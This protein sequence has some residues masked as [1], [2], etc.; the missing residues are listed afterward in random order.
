[1][2]RKVIPFIL[3]ILIYCGGGGESPSSRGKGRKEGT[4]LSSE[5][6]PVSPTTNTPINLRVAALSEKNPEYRWTV[7]GMEQD[8]S[9]STLS[10]KY[11]SEGDTV[12]CSVLINDKEKKKIGPIVIQNTPPQIENVEIIPDFIHH[13]VD[14]SVEVNYDEPDDDEVS[15]DVK[16]Y[17]NSKNSGTGLKLSGSKIKAG[18]SVYAEVTP[19]DESD[20]GETAETK[21]II[22]GNTP[23]EMVSGPPQ[24][25]GRKMNYPMKAKDVDGD[26]VTFRLSEGP[27]GMDIKGRNLVWEAPEIEK[28][29]VF[30]VE[31][32]LEDE[33]GGKTEVTYDL[34]LTRKKKE[35][36][37]NKE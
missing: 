14:V 1:M 5:Y 16:W 6:T 25:S 8:V 26:S 19:M 36:T 11:F 37:G 9:V 35:K 28:D 31:I 23:P 29:T 2:E 24:I 13:G 22:V 21:T 30:P 20:R 34:R 32:I 17:I 10:P 7:N 18:D 27:S 15:T 4:V 33:R 3:L 12:Y